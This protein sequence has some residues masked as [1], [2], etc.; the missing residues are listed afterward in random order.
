[1]EENFNLHPLN[2]HLSNMHSTTHLLLHLK[3]EVLSQTDSINTAWR[4]FEVPYALSAI[5]K[6]DTFP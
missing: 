1:M 4:K 6:F 2:D 3:F 5:Y